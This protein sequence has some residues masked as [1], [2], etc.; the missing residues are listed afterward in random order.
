MTWPSST[1]HLNVTNCNSYSNHT[2]VKKVFLDLIS[3]NRT[4][5]SRLTQCKSLLLYLKDLV[6]NLWASFL[7]P[8][9]LCMMHLHPRYHQFAKILCSG[10]KLDLGNNQNVQFSVRAS[11]SLN[12]E[13]EECTIEKKRTQ[14]ILSRWNGTAS[15]TGSL[16][17]DSY[18]KFLL[19][20]DQ[21]ANGVAFDV[22][23]VLLIVLVWSDFQPLGCNIL[24]LF[25]NV[26]ED[27]KFLLK[28]FYIYEKIKE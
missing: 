19:K 20:W 22:L 10:M 11:A 12:E 18:S 3:G 7:L 17:A 2:Q 1:K 6:L 15:S 16:F 28:A 14:Y 27:S 26:Q 21:T 4:Q 8:H 13:K 23:E 5:L 25:S 9:C 24:L